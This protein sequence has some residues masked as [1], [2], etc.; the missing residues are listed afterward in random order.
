MG[1]TI[2]SYIDHPYVSQ[3]RDCLREEEDSKVRCNVE[4]GRSHKRRTI[5]EEV[6]GVRVTGV[7]RSSHPNTKEVHA[8]ELTGARRQRVSVIA[9][10]GEWDGDLDLPHVDLWIHHVPDADAG[11][12]AVDVGVA[13]G[14][15]VGWVVYLGSIETLAN[16]KLQLQIV[17]RILNLLRDED[18]HYLLEI[19]RLIATG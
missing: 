15:V 10:Y 3:L 12:V 7:S 16:W 8:P 11:S 14:G 18:F 9:N 17:R 1:T 5:G 13:R 4:V 6:T 2:H 19:E